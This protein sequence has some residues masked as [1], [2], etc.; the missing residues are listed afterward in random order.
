MAWNRE[1]DFSRTPSSWFSVF[2]TS[3][4]APT[5]S[6]SLPFPLISLDSLNG[7]PI[8]REVEPKIR[9]GRTRPRMSPRLER[10]L[11]SKLN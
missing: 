9:A 4:D 5:S 6:E 2:G 3:R 1:S 11:Q 10:Q 8:K 7:I